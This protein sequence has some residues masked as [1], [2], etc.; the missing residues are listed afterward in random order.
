MASLVV[1]G[2]V[3]G[4]WG[5]EIHVHLIYGPFIIN[6]YHCTNRVTETIMCMSLSSRALHH[7]LVLGSVFVEGL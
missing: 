2:R 6:H 4:G 1:I 3:L 7:L 5:G